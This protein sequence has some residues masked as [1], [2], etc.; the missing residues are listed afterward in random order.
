LRAAIGNTIAQRGG[1]DVMDTTT[2]PPRTEAEIHE[3]LQKLVRRA[4]QGDGAAVPELRVALDVNGWVWR[5]Y[6]DAGTHA[7]AAWLGL[8]CGKNLMMR[9]AIERRMAEM[10]ATLAGED[11]SPLEQLLVARIL[12][13][14]LQVHYADGTYAQL[15]G[16]DPA[17]HTLM[18]RRQNAA[19]QRYVHAIKALATVRKLLRPAPSPLD[20][21]QRTVAE[22]PA[23]K[24]NPT[25]SRL[26]LRG[27][28]VLN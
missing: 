15:K 17:Q 13:C 21:L 4:E 7:T 1:N 23:E 5:D 10:R 8:V 19:Q 20:L 28:P 3:R 22:T 24:A 16:G 9:E 14:W 6:G 11:P 26:K 27:E 25:K 12:A 2:E 18:M